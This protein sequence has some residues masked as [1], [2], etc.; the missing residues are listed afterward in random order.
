MFLLRSDVRFQ[1]E[2]G[3][4][5]NQT[6]NEFSQRS[7][8]FDAVVIDCYLPSKKECTNHLGIVTTTLCKQYHTILSTFV[9]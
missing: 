5:E 7:C 2:L 3:F 9:T 8:Q 6:M 4:E 1:I